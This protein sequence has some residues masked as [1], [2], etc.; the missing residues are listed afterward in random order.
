MTRGKCV[1]VIT[2]YHGTARPDLQ[3]D[4]K[5]LIY[6]VNAAVYRT[7]VIHVTALSCGRPIAFLCSVGNWQPDLEWVSW[8]NYTQQWQDVLSDK[9]TSVSRMFFGKLIIF[10]Q[11][12]K[13]F[14]PTYSIWSSIA[15]F[16]GT[17]PLDPIWS[18]INSVYILIPHYF[19]I[20]FNIIIFLVMFVE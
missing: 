10:V 18:H 8:R 11:L 19:K 2:G 3:T 16:T 20:H 17:S 7:R 12:F 13:K 15:S 1:K 14:L 9:V 4:F 5:Q 6:V